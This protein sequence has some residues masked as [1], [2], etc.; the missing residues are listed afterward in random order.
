ML[1][2]AVAAGLVAASIHQYGSDLDCSLGY[3]ALREQVTQFAHE[4]SRLPGGNPMFDLY[5]DENSRAVYTLT[6]LENPA[7]PAIFM[8]SL[9][10][11]S[12]PATA[13]RSA[14]GFGD[15]AAFES[16][17]E[18]WLQEPPKP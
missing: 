9:A 16:L 14:C 17:L 12:A 11:Q 1:G 15:K 5:S 10:P 18:F 2:L 13:S 7:H 6:A 4:P 8:R 3:I